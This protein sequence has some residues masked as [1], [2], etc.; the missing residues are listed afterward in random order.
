MKKACLL[1]NYKK[2]FSKGVKWLDNF[3]KLP[4]SPTI[5][6]ANE[7]F[8]ALPIKQFIKINE[9]WFEN[10]VLL[11]KNGKFS[12]EKKKVTKKNMEK[13]FNQGIDENQNFIEFSPDQ[14]KFLKN[15]SRYIKK[16]FGGVL[17]IDYG[18]FKSKMSNTLQSVK[19]HKKNTQITKT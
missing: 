14:E 15:L 2:K 11:N 4:N 13:I 19:N 8:D 1:K 10:F 17:L 12:L 3:D 7:F 5:F 6:L 9:E 18:Y 16:N